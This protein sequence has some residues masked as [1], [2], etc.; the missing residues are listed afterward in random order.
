[1]NAALAYINMQR[2]CLSFR[3]GEGDFGGCVGRVA[4][5]FTRRPRHLARLTGPGH[6]PRSALG[7]FGR[8]RLLHE[9]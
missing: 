2:V 4:W 8:G 3:R 1:M 6:L 5:S 9:T 7:I